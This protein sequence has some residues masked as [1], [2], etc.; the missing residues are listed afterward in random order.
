V[1]RLVDALGGHPLAISLAFNR[2]KD[3][4]LEAAEDLPRFLTRA[5][6]ASHGR[7]PVERTLMKLPSERRREKRRSGY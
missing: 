3:Y 4:R 5:G 6:G 2:V 1:A 7:L